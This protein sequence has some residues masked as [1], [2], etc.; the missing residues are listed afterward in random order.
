M[1]RLFITLLLVLSTTSALLAQEGNR[2]LG[3]YITEK[4]NAK[5][6]ITQQNNLYIGTL[7]WTQTPGATDKNNPDTNERHKPLVGKRILTGF[8][9][10]GKNTWEHGKIYDPESGKTYSCKI[11][12]QKD[13]SL[14]V[15]GFVGVSLLGRTT[16][17]KPIQE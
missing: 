16:I 5:V 13:G 10:T 7:I 8:E 2:I 3:S 9:Y 14:R 6:S 17:W 15:R 12:R 4:G 11:T 1:K